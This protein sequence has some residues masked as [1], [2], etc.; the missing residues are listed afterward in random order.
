[1]KK[2]RGFVFIET[3]VVVAILT[4]SLLMTYSA[5]S[6]AIIKEKTRL[7]YN[8]S[9]YLYRTYYIEKF[10]KYF[11]LDRMKDYL[12]Q[13]EKQYLNE[14]GKETLGIIGFGCSADIIQ[15]E[16]NKAFCEDMW[17]ELHINNLYFTHSDV[18]SLQNC[19][20]SIETGKCAA[21][22]QMR[23]TASAYVKTIGGAFTNGY[24]IVVEF[25]ESKNGSSCFIGGKDACVY[26]YATILLGEIE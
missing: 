14:H 7:K 19:T 20:K 15:D 25:A 17:K 13:Y 6:T 4:I 21:L 11:R 1:M 12:S 2:K 3:I 16:E 9:V 10:F 5:Y 8:D 24:R 23:D 22:L 18:S 26:Y